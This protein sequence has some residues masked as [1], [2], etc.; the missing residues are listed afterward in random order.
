M[1]LKVFTILFSTIFIN[2]C[3]DSVIDT[4]NNQKRDIDPGNI[5]MN[6]YA[7]KT[8]KSLVIPPDLTSPQSQNSFRISEY[9]SG[10]NE[11]VVSFSGSEETRD[12]NT[13]I[14]QNNSDVRVERSG[15]RRWLIINKSS[16]IVWESAKDFFRQEGFS[17]K[18]SNKKIGIL[19]TDFL[20]NYPEIP[21][22]SLG[23][24]RSMLSKALTARY[25]LPII[26]KYRLRVEPID[27]KSTEV[28]LT[29]FSMKEKLAKSGNVEST[30]WEA[31][32]KD[33]ALE[34]EMLYRLMVYMTGDEVNSRQKILQASEQKNIETKVLDNFNGY[35]KLQFNSNLYET[36][37]SINWALDQLNIEIEDKDIKER[38]FYIKSV[39]TSNIGI[40]SS[41]L[42]TDALVK[43]YQIILKSLDENTTEVFFNDI[44]GENEQE[45]KDYSYDFFRNMQKVF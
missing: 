9:V 36:W 15:Q 38:S 23:L 17:I 29:L 40:I 26:D 31:Y 3:V 25:T 18:K 43:T 11:T 19:E 44:S 7:D 37:D 12:K 35:A 4:S 5:P 21:E 41:I 10:V 27:E 6:Y 2:A 20:E 22:R 33:L 30:I 39:G 24:I 13:K 14:L 32:E 16:D 28:H 42:G 1:Q 8:V 45:T 34:T